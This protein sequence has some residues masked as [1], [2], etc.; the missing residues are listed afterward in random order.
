MLHG[1]L[2]EESL[3]RKASDDFA[4]GLRPTLDTSAFSEVG[5]LVVFDIPVYCL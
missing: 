2:V 1:L 4:I 5:A 3:I